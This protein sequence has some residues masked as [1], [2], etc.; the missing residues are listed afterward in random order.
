[1]SGPARHGV[2]HR[3][4][5]PPGGLKPFVNRMLHSDSEAAGPH[6]FPIPPTGAHYLTFVYGSPMYIRY[7]Q[8]APTRTPRLFVG[9][10][11]WKHCPTCHSEGRVGLVGIEFTATGLH[12]LFGIDCA[13]LTDRI[14]SLDTLLPGAGQR[15][16]QALLEAGTTDHRFALLGQV[17]QSRAGTAPET[18]HLDRAIA[19]IEQHRGRIEVDRLAE[20]S[21]LSRRQLNRQ[22]LKG[23]GIGP[24][25]FAKIVQL[26]Q[27]FAALQNSDSGELQAIAQ[28]AGYYD[29]A[30]FIHDFQ[31][32]IGA[33]PSAFLQHPDP[34][35][36]IYL[37]THSTR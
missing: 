9:G 21:W 37:R 2:Q 13:T 5:S 26:K 3:E 25:H 33:N 11:V 15:L 6:S 16:E 34:F 27:A 22:F 14:E 32:L 24:K 12:R 8:Q 7:G 10:Q 35:L 4:Y 28:R 17:L 23:V 20:Q 30:H 1:M 29:Q 18:P 31:R 19:L 36:D